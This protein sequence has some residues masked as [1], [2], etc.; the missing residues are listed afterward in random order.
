MTQEPSSEFDPAEAFEAVR[1]ELS[2][3]HNAVLGLTARRTT[4]LN[5]LENRVHLPP[6][7]LRTGASIVT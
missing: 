7:V 6:L 4:L 5:G 3:L 1:H 2:L